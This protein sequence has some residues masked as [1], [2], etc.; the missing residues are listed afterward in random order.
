M[1]NSPPVDAPA[2]DPGFPTRPIVFLALASFA[3]LGMI[4]SIDV[5]LPQIAAEMNVTVGAAAVVVT[6]Y[7]LSHG[8]T[9]LIIGPIGDR[10]GKYRTIT[11]A[12][13]LSA[14]VVAVCGLAQ[15]LSTLT[16]LR[17]LSGFTVGWIIPLAMAFIGDVVPYERRQQALGSFLSGQIAG[18][19]TGQAASGVLG[20]MF[21]WRVV[22]FVL[23]GLFA[24][25]TAVLV[26]ELATSPRT[27][28]ADRRPVAPG[29]PFRDY[30]KVLSSR[31]SQFIL[32]VVLIE[33]GLVFSVF[34]FIGADL[35]LRFG[36]SFTAVGFV[37]AAFGIGGI[38]YAANVRWLVDL[39]G[40]RGIANAGGVLLG[41][42]FLMLAV[43]TVWWLAPIAVAGIGAGFYMLHNTLQTVCTQMAPE[44]RATAVALFASAFYIG[45]TAGVALAAPLVDHIGVPPLYAAS[46]LC[47]PILAVV[48]T[49]RL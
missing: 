31:W 24:I 6:A 17:L 5:L 37:I 42:S 9:Q 8:T 15:T 36:L 47:L 41:L 22:F 25:A 33:A 11:V 20:D 10:L 7:V 27:R 34:A 13:G 12:C 38:A 14:I 26:Y 30:G 48:F 4:R 35:H 18:A 19:I 40:P 43:Q 39:M 21:G 49:R 2:D 16:A 1:A 45:Q 3:S 23:A 32:V 28:A 44:A 46:A 29:N